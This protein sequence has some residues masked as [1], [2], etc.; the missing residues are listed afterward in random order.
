MAMKPL[1]IGLLLAAGAVGGMVVMKVA[2]RAHPAPVRASV[3]AAA[4]AAVAVTPPA[5][6]E[7]LPSP[8]PEKRKKAA[9]TAAPEVEVAQNQPP[10]EVVVPPAEPA[11]EPAP[12]PAPEPAAA[13]AAP[14]PPPPPVLPARVTIKAG[15]L[16]PVRLVEALST[17]RSAVGDL[18]TATLD[19][20]LV[21]DGLVIAERGAQVEGRVV[22][23]DKGGRVKGVSSLAIELTRLNTADGQRI[24]IRTDSFEHHAPT[25]HGE[26]VRKAGTAA[27]VGAAIG[28]IAGGGKG[29][30][31]GAAAGGAAGAGVVMATRGEAAKLASETRIRFRLREPVTITERRTI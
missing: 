17:D 29:A 12:V 16:L 31:I 6:A 18:F 23:S 30:G 9:R 11:P 24:A 19:Q 28:A 14:P 1:Q 2:Q 8:F 22:A 15:T 7:P 26:D 25:S 10:V 3:V 21:V 5:P 27:V 4:P 20:V 13:P